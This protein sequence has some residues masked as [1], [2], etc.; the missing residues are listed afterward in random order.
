VQ[1]L[2]LNKPSCS[3]AASN[4]VFGD[5]CSGV[6]K[7]LVVAY[8]CGGGGDNCP[9]DPNKTEPG[10]CG[11]G[12]P[13]GS[14]NNTFDTS[15]AIPLRDAKYR[16]SPFT[17]ILE[18]TGAIK[19]PESYEVFFDTGSSDLCLPYGALNKSKLTVLKANTTDCWGNK[20]DKV[21]GQIVLKSRNGSTYV[22]D[23][24]VFWARYADD[25][26]HEPW[27]N[28]ISGGQ[29]FSGSIPYELA[30]KYFPNEMGFGIISDSAN[31][32]L[33][34]GYKS[35]K[36]YLKIGNDKTLN[37]TL[38]WKNSVNDGGPGL[39]HAVRGFTVTFKFPEVNGS[40]LSDIV[41][42]NLM[43]TVDTGAPDLTMRISSS[44]PQRNSHKQFFDNDVPWWFSSDQ[45]Q[46]LKRGPT[47]Q[48]GFTATSGQT[49]SYAFPSRVFTSTGT[50]V[51]SP[52]T[53]SIGDWNSS[54]PWAVSTDTPKNRIN[55]G[56]SI[57]FYWPVFYFDIANN[58]VG[59]YCK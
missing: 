51:D 21:K 40:K 5:P 53:T 24:Y 32:N 33:K 26:R 8:T 57:Y 28:N 35:L 55:L 30:K 58:R 18:G 16:K 12:V 1:S 6:P 22:L 42:P 7:N 49:C 36:S 2:C 46:S 39:F 50:S 45:C 20:A 17:L 3:V 15:M 47:V 9:N 13:E 25:E 41:V 56:N 14:C 31:S 34:N 11:C 19:G 4:A 29:P 10:L 38:I 27:G 48:I 37:N 23:D 59:I 54:I 52:D 43:A 44:N